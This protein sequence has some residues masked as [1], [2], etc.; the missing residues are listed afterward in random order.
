MRIWIRDFFEPGF[1]IRDGNIRIRDVKIRIRDKHHESELWYK[2]RILRV[3]VVAGMPRVCCRNL[4]YSSLAFRARLIFTSF[5][6]YRTRDV[7]QQSINQML[8]IWNGRVL[9]TQD[10]SSNKLIFFL[11]FSFCLTVHFKPAFQVNPGF[12]WLKIEKEKNT[13]EKYGSRFQRPH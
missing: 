7:F 10:S 4:A 2:Y 8:L 13:A 11:L 1:E 12:W 9:I 6:S 5:S 3:S